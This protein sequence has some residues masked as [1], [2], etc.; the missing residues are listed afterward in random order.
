[1]ATGG[2]GGADRGTGRHATT[3]CTATMGVVVFMAA[4]HITLWTYRL[5]S[6]FMV[7]RD[8][9]SSH[10]HLSVCTGSGMLVACLQPN[11]S[12]VT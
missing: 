11:Q 1:M 9:Q 12:S 5:H 10:C 6:F 4:T 8:T 2:G 3:P 7:A